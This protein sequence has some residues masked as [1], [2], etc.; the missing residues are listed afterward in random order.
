MRTQLQ[1]P[2]PIGTVRLCAALLGLASAL[3][4]HAEAP[5]H[6]DDA[7]TLDQGAMKLEA[8]IGRDGKTRGGELLWGAGVLSWSSFFGH[9]DRGGSFKLSELATPAASHSYWVTGIPA[10]SAA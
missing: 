1:P 4:A 2:H 9:S 8:G 6:T 5:M 3:A 7:G 10:W